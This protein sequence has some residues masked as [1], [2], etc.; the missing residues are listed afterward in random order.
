MN[1]ET[2]FGFFAQAVMT[3]VGTS[4]TNLTGTPVNLERIAL[5]TTN[6][7]KLRWS[8]VETVLLPQLAVKADVAWVFALTQHDVAGLTR[9]L[10]ERMPFHRL[11]EQVVSTAAEPFNFVS[12]RR[13]RLTGL[14]V[15]R[16]VTGLTAHHL[17]GEVNYTM[18][19]GL[20]SV[21]RANGFSLRLLVTAAGRDRIEARAEQKTTQRALFSITEG[22]YLC[23]PQW[24]PPPPPPGL[25][26]GAQLSELMLNGWLQTFFGLNDGEIANRLFQ[27]P[28]GLQCQ[29]ADAEALRAMATKDGPPT[30][31]R[32]Q[33][34]DEKA[35]ELFV[36]LP[37][38][39]AGQLIRLSRSG[40][41][42]FL[43][44]LFRALF[45]EAGR[46]WERFSEVPMA[47]RLLAVRRIPTDA[48]D[49]VTKRLE[50]GGLA[51]RQI[52]RMDEGHLEWMLAIPPHTWHWLMRA[53]AK[54]MAHPSSGLPNR[55]AIFR[56]TGW[57][58]GRVP[59]ARMAAF[60]SDRELQD[61]IRVL[62]QAGLAEPALAA[63]AEALEGPFRRRWLEAM[64]M[65]LRERTER[66]ELAEG[67]AARRHLEL[68]RALIPLGRA[69]RLPPGRLAQWVS[70]YGE[71]YFS[72]CQYV[73]D[74]LLP[75]RHLVYGMD[76]ASLSRLLFDAHSN[77]LVPVLSWAEFPVVDQV[78]RAIS[79]GF[80]LRL[81]EDV[82][83]L[84]AGI[85]AFTAQQA[86]LDLYRTAFRGLSQG[87]YLIR[88]TPAQR[89]RD[90]IRVL[91]EED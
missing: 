39:V 57:G 80:A 47:W 76:R 59:W 46:L 21:P 71:F 54:G 50:G 45:G 82:G 86:Q 91:D 81:F 34:G 7:L 19:T 43:G 17:G 3:A 28:V 68:T 18:A 9:L 58:Q 88:A 37:A 44:D 16:N 23:R 66:T 10:G 65:M 67:E 33:L 36:V 24:D 72:R 13:N 85:H 56:A 52:A 77:V 90:L 40:A 89:L 2:Y 14:Q 83:D 8:D 61:L 70:L 53:T 25:E 63:V 22:A 55:Q 30:V 26:E 62:G 87:R 38:P 41:E 51:V 64:P 75:L 29:L 49:A 78:R 69:G 27:R 11:L 48:V 4:M 15:S 73:I 84:R 1:I 6:T 42:R 31:A 74:T 32:L 60:L 20:F 5:S 35:L 12:K 79:P